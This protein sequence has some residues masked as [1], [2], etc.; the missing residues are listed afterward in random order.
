[1]ET[2][3]IVEYIDRQKIMCAIVL[4]V[5]NQKLRLLTETDREVK[6]APHRLVHTG[7][8]AADVSMSRQKMT[9]HLKLTAGRRN[10]LI[11]QIDI[12]GL[13]EVLSAEGEW[14]DLATMTTLCFPDNPSADHESAV[15]RAVFNNR[16][17]FKFD[18][19]RF[20]PNTPEQV[21]TILAQRKEDA[22][23]EAIIDAGGTWLKDVIDG[24]TPE[25]TAETT[26]YAHILK[27]LYLD[28]T[29]S[30]DFPLG[31][32]ILA[33]AG[34][35]DIDRIFQVLVTL[36]IF[37]ADE[38]IDLLKADVPTDFSDKIIAVADGIIAVADGIIA[39]G[40]GK[41][42]AVADGADG[43]EGI[44]AVADGV[45]LDPARKDFTCLPIMTIDGAGT[46]DYDDA[47]SIDTRGEQHFI[48]VHIMDVAH[49][50]K[51]GDAI[52]LEAM[53][54][55]SSIYMP[56]SKIPM[57][58]PQLAEGLCSL[59]ADTVRPAIS[60]M[61]KLNQ[62]AD[63][64]DYEIV[65]SYIRVKQQLTYY[66]VNLMAN[67]NGD[68]IILKD[69]AEQLRRRR[70]AQGAVQI[71]LPEIGV[72]LGEDGEITVNTVNRESPARIIVEELMI[73]ANGLMAGFLA[74]KNIPAVFRTQPEPKERLYKE[75]NGTLF[76]N[77][78]QRRLLSRFV[79]STTPERHSGL[80]LDAYVT[81][82]S[83]IRKYFDLI[84]QR[85]L[86][87]AFGLETPYSADELSHTMQM[88]EEPMR[89]VGMIQFRRKRYWLLK[90]LETQVGTKYQAIVVFKRRNNY[91]IL[92]PD[93]MLECNLPLSTSF[94]L[95]PED[96]IEVTL[97]HVNARQ[98]SIS[99]FWA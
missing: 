22:R 35:S 9:T 71:S 39:R 55:A 67:D 33:K 20:F 31:K 27:A 28:R 96:L 50:I 47:I 26:G 44:I 59:K 10:A 2:G 34:I 52:D 81:A 46:L 79:L 21:E 66:A 49:Y 89:A 99:V 8:D 36:G 54:R 74:E 17:Y 12:E 76:Q 41:G 6:L 69:I 80:G 5:K 53:Q 14:V 91:Q 82:T 18:R 84:T 23:K 13:W 40:I 48:G 45:D 70:L 43:V 64:I 97:Q 58:P 94:D 61:M 1:M 16:L 83:P 38:N 85:Q 56:D 87:S 7:K 75:E 90:Y 72:M 88:L 15:V 68:I 24:K 25:M 62:A 65:P 95:K 98:D 11:E 86:R 4:D 29:D 37:E 63:V 51:R 32:A 78:R 93:Y 60:V 73:L 30:D 3:R 92:I 42:I 57:L 19:D 77:Y